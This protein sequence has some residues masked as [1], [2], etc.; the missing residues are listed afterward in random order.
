MKTAMKKYSV[1]ILLVGLG[2]ALG[3]VVG[4]FDPATVSASPDQQ[5]LVEVPAVAF[6]VGPNGVVGPMDDQ[7][8]PGTVELYMLTPLGMQALREIHL[9]TQ[10]NQDDLQRLRQRTKFFANSVSTLVE[11]INIA[12]STFLQVVGPMD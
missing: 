7:C 6:C 2:L 5:G 4:R 3:L 11:D 1:R 8:P 9:Q 12:T 10:Q